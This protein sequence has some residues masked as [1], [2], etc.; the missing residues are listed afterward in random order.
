MFFP[1]LG[2]AANRILIILGFQS[3]KRTVHHFPCF[4]FHQNVITFLFWIILESI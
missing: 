3:I 2:V 4:T 1:I